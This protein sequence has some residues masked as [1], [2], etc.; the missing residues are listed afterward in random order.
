[1]QIRIE[2]RSPQSIPNG[3]QLLFLFDDG[4]FIG[5]ARKINTQSSGQ[6]KELFD[7]GDFTAQPSQTMLLHKVTGSLAD[8]LLLIGLGDRKTADHARWRNAC[9]SAAAAIQTTTSNTV[10]TDAITAV[11][12]DLLDKFSMAEHLTREMVSGAYSFTL[13]ERSTSLRQSKIEQLL[14]TTDSKNVE[15]ITLAANRG[16]ATGCGMATARDLGNLAPNICTPEYLADRAAELS[17]SYPNLTHESLDEA[18][19]EKLGMGAL[20]A[21]S[22]GSD[23]PGRLIC[24]N[25]QGRKRAGSPIVLVGKGI[26]FDT[27]G[28]SI[29]S[30]DGLDEM[31]Y[32]MCGAAAV[33]G[34]MEAVARLQL[35][36]NLVGLVAAAE[37]MPDGN[38]AR[39]G[40]VVISMSG[41]SIEI[42]NTDAEGRLVLCDALT[43]AER[44]KPAAVIDIATLTGACIVALGKSR[45]GVMGNHQD[46]INQLIQAGDTSGD[47]T[48]QLPID[49]EYQSLLDS[50]FAD[51]ANIGGRAAGAITAACFL[52][53]FAKKFHWAHLDIAGIASISGKHKG[54]TGRPVPLLMSY[55]FAR[56]DQ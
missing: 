24:M 34:V 52:S 56:A 49:D 48:W 11:K 40:D 31:K 1:M 37:N 54:A 41:Q 3:C 17:S 22:Q 44:F 35:E 50:N 39:P 43:Y 2:K 6:L 30:S 23:Q 45:S 46:T 20:L 5:S 9:Q 10:Y 51:M 36:I 12:T 25:Y 26:T 13:H 38:A 16:H 53:R 8:R 28:I 33:F 21:V 7:S 27:G 18:A 15:D 4:K 29:K 47:R 55:L 42:L 19:M 14:I 32:D